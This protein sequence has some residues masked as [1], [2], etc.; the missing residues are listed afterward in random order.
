VAVINHSPGRDPARHR[1]ADRAE[2]CAHE[3]IRKAVAQHRHQ[4]WVIMI[5]FLRDLFFA[6]SLSLMAVALGTAFA[7]QMVG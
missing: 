7:M 6:A 1:Q 3:L 2:S 4:S 5:D